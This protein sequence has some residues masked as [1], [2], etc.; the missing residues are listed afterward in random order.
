M[1]ALA[2]IA[3]LSLLQVEKIGIMEV[4]WPL[5]DKTWLNFM[6]E[7]LIKRMFIDNRKNE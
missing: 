1:F 3:Q 4:K 6:L 2:K 7:K 5:K